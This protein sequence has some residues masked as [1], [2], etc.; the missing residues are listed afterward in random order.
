M[1][2]ALPETNTLEVK[3]NKMTNDIFQDLLI[4]NPY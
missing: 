2:V 4:V 1:D 3:D